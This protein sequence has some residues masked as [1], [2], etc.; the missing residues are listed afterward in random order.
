[1]DRT[2]FRNLIRIAY[3]SIFSNR[4]QISYK[5]NNIIS[6]YYIALINPAYK[7]SSTKC[8]STYTNVEDGTWTGVINS[9]ER[10]KKKAKNLE[11]DY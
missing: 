1:M 9:F 7:V 2:T 3:L 10:N 11:T 5:G 6:L 4:G 8:G